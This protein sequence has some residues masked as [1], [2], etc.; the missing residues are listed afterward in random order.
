THERGGKKPDPPEAGRKYPNR[1]EAGAGQARPDRR[2]DQEGREE[3][4]AEAGAGRQA[5]RGA[6]AED[7]RTPLRSD[8]D[9]GTARQARPDAP[10]RG[11]RHAEFQRRT[12]PFEGH[13][14]EQFSDL[15]R[16]VQEPGPSLLEKAVWRDRGEEVR[17]RIQ[18]Q[19]QEGWLA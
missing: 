16:D 4:A 18:Y 7:R 9:R 5:A 14:G 12:R 10:G 2:G 1:E 11:R 15:G 13:G 8:P 19:A 17:G 6:E 3:A